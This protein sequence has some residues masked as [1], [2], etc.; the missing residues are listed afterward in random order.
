MGTARILALTLALTSATFLPRAAARQAVP[1]SASAGTN[2]SVSLFVPQSDLLGSIWVY[3]AT[4]GNRFTSPSSLW[5][6]R[7]LEIDFVG[8][9]EFDEFTPGRPR[10]LADVPSASR[11]RLPMGNGS[12][13]RYVASRA[14]GVHYGFVH[15][16]PAGRAM[17]LA[18]RLGSGRDGSAD[19]WMPRVSVAPD[20]QSFLAATRFFAGGDLI[21]VSLAGDATVTDRTPEQGPFRFKKNGLGLA[22]DWA[23]AVTD[24]G[25]LRY[26]RIPGERTMLVPLQGG[27]APTW[28]QGD[29]MFSRNQ[30]YAMTVAG[31]DSGRSHV[32]AFRHDGALVRVTEQAGNWAGAGYLP[33]RKNGPYMAISDDGELAAWRSNTVSRELFLARVPSHRAPARVVRQVTEPQLFDDTLD[34]IGLTRFLVP[35]RLTFAAGARDYVHGGLDR[36][37]FFSAHLEAGTD[38]VL[39]V[40]LS[41]TS[42]ELVPPFIEYGTLEVD[43][44]VWISKANRILVFDGQESDSIFVVRPGGGGVRN[45]LSGVRAF[46]LLMP[47]DE[48]VLLGVRRTADEGNEAQLLRV[49]S[50][51]QSTPTVVFSA[52]PDVDFSRPAARRDG[53]V[54][55]VISDEGSQLLARLNL[56]SGVV[57]VLT[58]TTTS[59]YGPAI[60]FTPGGSAITSLSN[61][62]HTSTLLVPFDGGPPVPLLGVFGSASLLPGN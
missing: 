27:F 40:N 8:R 53:W 59:S 45:I 28:W 23:V 54:A 2:G 26:R 42:G 57:D 7:L 47:H 11:L 1:S 61:A 4:A 17:A 22:H 3:D 14:D 16:D 20:G 41:G 9:T 30:R 19:P 31:I 36:T 60:G 44:A 32:W 46:D 24:Q 35:D 10:Y 33:E 37:D 18:D 38:R 49:D 5:S 51:L 55:F 39:A 6:L 21:E 56:A 13:Y 52:G 62:G 58:V 29:L 12:L 15:V 25:V 43:R 48:G 34:E 50:K